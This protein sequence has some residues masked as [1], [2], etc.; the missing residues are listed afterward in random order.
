MLSL[1]NQPNVV[2]NAKRGYHFMAMIQLPREA[3]L[4]ERPISQWGD[5]KDRL[6]KAAEESFE[7]LEKT[8]AA[9]DAD[10]TITFVKE[11]ATS[12]LDPNVVDEFIFGRSD[13]DASDSRWRLVGAGSDEAPEQVSTPND[14]MLSIS[15]LRQWEMVF[16]IRHPALAFASLYRILLEVAPRGQ[17]SKATQN[18]FTVNMTLRWSRRLY[19]L[20]AELSGSEPIVLDADDIISSPAVVQKF[21]ADLGMD[22]SRVRRTWSPSTKEE[23]EKESPVN[24]RFFSTIN[25]SSGIMTDKL[26]GDIDIAS[27]VAKWRLEFGE[28]GARKL[29]T[30]VRAAMPDYLYLRGKRQTL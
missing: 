23:I 28:E 7:S 8:R 11:H 29:E 3:D 13:V 9:G 16:L 18:I 12:L 25:A 24:Q 21:A 26:A 17:V 4:W 14:T 20:A 5:D 6:R 27:E 19:D 22:P 30:W 1:D 2:E 10:G 15:Y